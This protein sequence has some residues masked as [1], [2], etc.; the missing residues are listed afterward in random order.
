LMRV[1]FFVKSPESSEG[2]GKAR[3]ALRNQ[4]YSR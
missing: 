4:P 2:S 1:T 3:K